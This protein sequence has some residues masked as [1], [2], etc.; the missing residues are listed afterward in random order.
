MCKQNITIFNELLHSEFSFLIHMSA[1]KVHSLAAND[2]TAA[3]SIAGQFDY[4][5]SYCQN[6]LRLDSR[7]LYM[8][9]R[10][11]Y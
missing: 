11:F 2:Y 5:F 8:I 1:L 4:L 7:V 6:V 3:F 10:K 9:L